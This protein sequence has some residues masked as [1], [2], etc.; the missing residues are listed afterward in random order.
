MSSATSGPPAIS[1]GDFSRLADLVRAEAGISLTEAKAPLVHSRLS[2]RLKALNL[3]DFDSYF[4]LVSSA[5]GREER[6][7]ML[8]ALTTNVTKFF[9][10]PHHFEQLAKDTLP[11]IF[12]CDDDPSE[13]A[14]FMR[15][16]A[17]RLLPCSKF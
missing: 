4:K 7:H 1:P 6:R 10:E 2:R 9:R 15:N 8:S 11:A 17:P 13:I 12:G 16:H 5:D 3:G 14:G